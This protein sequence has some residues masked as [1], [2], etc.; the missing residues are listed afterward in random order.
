M[1]GSTA[2][3]DACVRQREEEH[4]HSSDCEVGSEFLGDHVDWLGVVGA[5]RVQ[6]EQKVWRRVAHIDLKICD[7]YETSWGI[8]PLIPIQTPGESI[9]DLVHQRL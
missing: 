1:L 4:G 9:A 3:N 2:G 5:K 6:C 7:S 8:V